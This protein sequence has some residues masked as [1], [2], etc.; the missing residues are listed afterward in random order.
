MGYPARIS[1]IT[2]SPSLSTTPIKPES[3]SFGLWHAS[4]VYGEGSVTEVLDPR[5]EALHRIQLPHMQQL[6]PTSGLPLQCESAYD[7]VATAVHNILREPVRWDLL[8]ETLSTFLDRSVLAF[9]DRSAITGLATLNSAAIENQIDNSKSATEYAGFDDPNGDK[10]AVVGMSARLP[11]ATDVDALWDVL[12]SGRDLHK[13]VPTDRFPVDTHF[14]VT[15][16]KQNTSHSPY[17]C[18][19]ENPGMFDA[20]FFHM[21]PR[22]AAQTDPM[23][24]LALVTAYEAL[25]MSG[26]VLNSTPSTQSARVGTFY[27]QTSDDWREVNAAQDISTYFIPGGVRAF[28]P[29]RISYHFGFSGPSYSVDTACS[30]SM[31]AIQIGCTSLRSRE[32]DTVV[33]GGLNVLTA[34]DIFAGLSRGQFL[35]KTGPCQ[36]WDINADGY[37]RADGVG[38]VVLKRY[39][40]AIAE[41]DNILGVILATATNHSADAISITHPHAGNQAQLFESVL[42]NAGVNP[43][44][45]S[46]IEMHG[47]GTQAGDLAETSSVTEVF[48]PIGARSPA[49]TLHIGAIKSNIGHSEA[50]AGVSALIKVLLMLQNNIIPPH[51]GIKTQLN[52]ALPDFKNRNVNIASE[53]YPWP[54]TPGKSRLT[55]LNNFSAAGGNTAMLLQEHLPQPLSD[56]PDPRT[57]LPFLVSARTLTSLRKNIQRLTEFLEKTP[58]VSLGSLSYT[59]T[60]RRMQHNYRVGTVASDVDS[61]KKSLSQIEVVGLPPIPSRAPKVAFTYTGQ[62]A[63]YINCARDLLQQSIVFRDVLDHYNHLAVSMGGPSFLP[64]IDGSAMA[65]QDFAPSA[66]HVATT[67]MQMALTRLWESWGLQPALVIGH[68]LGEYAALNAAGVLSDTDTIFLV[69]QRAKLLEEKCVAGTHAMLAV[70]ASIAEIEAATH[71]DGLT[72]DI[73]CIN[74]AKDVVL[75]GD[76][77]TIQKLSDILKRGAY[78]CAT[79]NLPYAFHSKQLDPVLEE[80]EHIARGAIF[81]KPKIP[82]L[83]PLYAQVVEDDI[84]TPEYLCNHA[85]KTVDF[86]GALQQATDDGLI[87]LK[88]VFVEIGLHPLCSK[89]VKSHF[90]T[91]VAALPSLQK[92]RSAWE[93][94]SKTVVALHCAAVS[95]DWRQFHRD[96]ETSHQLL[97]LPAYSF[98]EKNYWIDY[99]NDW[100]LH[101][102]EPRNVVQELPA[103]PVVV[104]PKRLSTSVHRVISEDIEGDKITVVTQTDL[105][106]PELRPVLMGHQVNDT[107]LCSSVRVSIMLIPDSMLT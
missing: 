71:A 11:G 81:N 19:I 53:A 88:T 62:G 60:A 106:A 67:C 85:R 10:I 42:H 25:E 100:C 89:M 14:D 23:H 83:S 99:V 94:L 5:F 86:T 16:K 75:A 21:S 56:K 103:P 66:V 9:G 47:T 95:L 28:A 55:F 105:S 104:P 52:P 33:A 65:D 3:S 45:I 38:S 12:A 72:Y 51:V 2:A 63:F 68:S 17:G 57:A 76:I 32:C 34:P 1:Q 8:Q 29:G 91:S 78:R 4:H 54:Q 50:A 20:R 80:F 84:F 77:N 43:L 96:Y 46:Y 27:G 41:K 93:V 22:E 90:G 15:G 79:L 59:L 40:D 97:Q 101:K 69:T 73:A 48:A 49:Q 31:A 58:D 92:D 35:S 74:S 6:S 39:E 44:D 98:E 13:R 37:C 24:R 64:M 18:F 107:P 102:I 70:N 26:F 30:S 36:T 87:D 82:V 61:L 7:L